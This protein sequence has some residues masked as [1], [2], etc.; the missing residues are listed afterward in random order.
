MARIANSSQPH[1]GVIDTMRQIH[2]PRRLER[3]EDQGTDSFFLSFYF[4]LVI[5][6]PFAL[7]ATPRDSS[8]EGCVLLSYLAPRLVCMAFT[9]GSSGRVRIAR[10]TSYEAT[11]ADTGANYIGARVAAAARPSLR[12][13]STSP[14]RCGYVAQYTAHRP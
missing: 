2:S 13:T 7:S 5:P 11:H 9:R 8:H 10:A 1:R 3:H 6:F 4:F 14:Q 12:S